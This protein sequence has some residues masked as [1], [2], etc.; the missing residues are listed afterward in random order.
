[1]IKILS[2]F[3][4]LIFIGLWMVIKSRAGRHSAAAVFLTE[5]T[6]LEARETGPAM[7]GSERRSELVLVSPGLLR[8]VFWF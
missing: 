4:P 1:M 8:N 6:A 5:R 7:D 2:V 3:V